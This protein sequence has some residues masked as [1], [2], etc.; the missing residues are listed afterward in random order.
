MSIIDLFRLDGKVAVVTG[1]S[2]GLGASFCEVLADAGADVVMAA[3]RADLLS[4]R[5]ERIAALGRQ[6][7]SVPTDVTKK[8]E[9]DA[10]IAA[11]VERFG[12]VDILVNNAGYGT[13]VPA[14]SETEEEFRNVYDVNVFG[15]YWTAQAAARVMLPGSSIINVASIGAFVSFGR[16]Q[17]AY[18]SS[19]AA[20]VGLTRDLAQQW[21]GRKG[22][23]V[24]ALAPGFILTEM[25]APAFVDGVPQGELIPAGRAGTPEEVGAAVVFLA[26]NAS[27]YMSGSTLVVDGGRCVY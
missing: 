19:K 27:S 15:L 8:D 3:R 11:A 21:T 26:S 2:S 6:A 23:R 24:N 17:A 16:P 18:I 14:L 13:A 20:V 7:I 1:A 12:K 4:E 22:I 9:C 5:E 25:T 10:L